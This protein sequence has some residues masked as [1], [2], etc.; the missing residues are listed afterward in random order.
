MKVGTVTVFGDNW[1]PAGALFGNCAAL[2]FVRIASRHPDR[3]RMQFGI[4]DPQLQTIELVRT[5]ATL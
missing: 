1:V 4:D 3:G 5:L 2:V